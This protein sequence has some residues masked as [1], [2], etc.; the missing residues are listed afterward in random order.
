VSMPH[1]DAIECFLTAI[2]RRDKPIVHVQLRKAQ[3]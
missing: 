3:E 2:P 1:I